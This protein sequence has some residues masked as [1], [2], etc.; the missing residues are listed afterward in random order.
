RDRAPIR[1]AGGSAQSRESSDSGQEISRFRQS[2][3]QIGSRFP[4]GGE[5]LRRCRCLDWST[6]TRYTVG[7][8][9]S[10]QIFGSQPG[11]LADSGQ[12]LR[13]DLVIV[14]ECEDEVLRI[15]STQCSVGTG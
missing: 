8:I 4:R 9:M 15:L 14:V 2:R 6:A 5:L 3:S 7:M 12:H 13:P 10:S 11:S 1:L